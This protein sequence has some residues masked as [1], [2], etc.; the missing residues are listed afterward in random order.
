MNRGGSRLA[1]LVL[2]PS[3][4]LGGAQTPL[5]E[6]RLQLAA[7]QEGHYPTTEQEHEFKG[8]RRH[9]YA[10]R[11]ESRGIIAEYRTTAKILLG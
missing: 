10:L 8:F 4:L 9:Q 5:A 11:H 6:A 3:A 2:A 7:Q 1:G